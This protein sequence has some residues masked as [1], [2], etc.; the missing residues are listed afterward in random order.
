LVLKELS[1]EVAVHGNP[2]HCVRRF[3]GQGA[4]Q[5]MTGHGSKGRE[6][7]V[8]VLVGL[9]DGTLPFYKSLSDPENL[10]EERRIFYVGLTRA[11]KLGLLTRVTMQRGRRQ[12]RSRFLASIPNECWTEWPKCLEALSAV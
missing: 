8:V 3:L 1:H 11:R 2:L 6:F 9:E 4:V 10:A 5:V 12:E 7:D